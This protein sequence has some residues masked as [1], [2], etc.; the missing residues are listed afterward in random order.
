MD[1]YGILSSPGDKEIP[2]F[3]Q[4][5]RWVTNQIRD[6]IRRTIA[7]NLSARCDPALSERK[8]CRE[9]MEGVPNRLDIWGHEPSP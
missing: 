8:D 9:D 5:P 6:A 1:K 2:L 3:D 7:R 4:D